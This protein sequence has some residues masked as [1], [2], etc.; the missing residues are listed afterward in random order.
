MRQREGGAVRGQECGATRG[1][2]CYILSTLV[3]IFRCMSRSIVISS[4]SS[5]DQLHFTVTKCIVSTSH[6]ILIYGRIKLIKQIY[7][8]LHHQN[9]SPISHEFR[10][11]PSSVADLSIFP[12]ITRF[13]CASFSRQCLFATSIVKFLSKSVPI[14]RIHH[15]IPASSRQCLFAASIV[16]FLTKSVPI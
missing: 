12:K 11:R 2:D 9:H 3:L 15:L 13:L 14:R 6:K 16:E 5:S 1:R 7:F 8:Q 10:A 4:F